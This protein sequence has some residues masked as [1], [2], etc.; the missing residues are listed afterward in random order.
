[1]QR[2]G[3]RLLRRGSAIVGSAPP[4]ASSA[5][6]LRALA[7][8]DAR[9]EGLPLVYQRL[10]TLEPISDKALLAGR[11]GDRGEA[12]QRWRNW[13]DD[14]GVPLVV[15]GRQG[16]GI[17]SFL[18][19][20]IAEIE[21]DGGSVTRA[22]L[23]DRIT[24]EATLAAHLATTLGL[25]PTDSLAHLS[26]AIFAAKASSLPSAVALDNLE[27]LYLRAPR[28]TEMMER[29]LTLWAETEPKVFWIGGVTESAWKLISTA[30]PTA[31]S[32]I[33]VFELEALGSAA[34]R[35]AITVRHR[36][37]GLAFRYQAP[38]GTAHR[39]RKRHR[40]LRRAD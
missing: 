29:L 24:D 35:S 6:T 30:E 23:T 40:R 1:V 5:R 12:M 10:I 37:R 36:R 18:N 28:G 33:D 38:R 31:V 4:A 8:K 19:V 32:Q 14:D 22:T 13:H 25:T 20:F 3:A 17:T 21:R 2:L 7:E 9:I 39:L 34:M 27:H 26:S 11:D 15:K 16:S